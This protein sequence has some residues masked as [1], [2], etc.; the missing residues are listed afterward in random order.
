MQPL[1]V[2]YPL[3]HAVAMMLTLVSSFTSLFMSLEKLEGEEGGWPK[4]YVF[5]KIHRMRNSSKHHAL[6]RCSNYRQLRYS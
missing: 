6:P 5:D 3:R 2:G 1:G 4:L